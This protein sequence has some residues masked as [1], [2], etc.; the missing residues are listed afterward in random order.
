MAEGTEFQIRSHFGSITTHMAVAWRPRS[1]P[2]FVP[3]E[4]VEELRKIQ[5]EEAEE[6]RKIQAEEAIARFSE[7][8]VAGQEVT[9]PL[10]IPDTEV[11]YSKITF[12]G[13]VNWR[14]IEKTALPDGISVEGTE[15]LD[16]DDFDDDDFNKDAT[17]QK[18]AQQSSLPGFLEWQTRRASETNRFPNDILRKT[19][20][21]D[22]LQTILKSALASG[23]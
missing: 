13:V 17:K 5:A 6:L 7:D 20:R 19:L 23:R 2:A 21:D 22:S 15:K 4:I 8:L 14:C 12:K 10:E 9:V 3:P 16:E 11:R 18:E 1:Q